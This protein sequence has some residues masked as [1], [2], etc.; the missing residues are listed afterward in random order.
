M[1]DESPFLSEE[2][3]RDPHPAWAE[4]RA[5]CPVMRQEAFGAESFHVLRHDDVEAVLRDSETFSSSINQQTMGPYMGELMLAMDGSQHVQYR[6]FVSHAFRKSALDRWERDLIRP[7]IDALVDAIAPHG[8][9]DLVRDV[10]SQYPVKVIAGIVGVPVED[11]VT[12]QGWAE[13]ISKGPLN[14][15]QGLAASRAMRE[16]LTPIVENRKKSPRDDLISDIVHVEIDGERI[17]DEH[18]YGFLRLLMPAGAE[19]T[20][21]VMGNCLLALLTHPGALGRAQ[22]EPEFLERAIEETLR[23]ETSVTMVNRVA[24][25]DAEV[26]GCKVP[27]GASL[28]LLVSSANRDASFHE[29]ADAWDPDREEKP[30]LAFGWGRHLCLGMH[31]ARR[32]LQVGI[33]TLLERLPGLALDPD[34]PTPEIVGY[35]F[36]GPESLPVIFDAAG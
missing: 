21:R 11:H 8:R 1:K 9:A 2:M 18:I 3:M 23:W 34:A 7:T 13:E 19:T 16:Y 31:L 26:A 5:R 32:E 14:P 29:R 35:A 22:R 28:I 24:T 4:G 30:H 6:S 27:K 12:F 36:R 33:G 15:E 10:T 25:R 20:F 17:D